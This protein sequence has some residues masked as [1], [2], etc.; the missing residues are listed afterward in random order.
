MN[1]IWIVADTFR[2]DH[3]GAYGNAAIRTP[4]LDA[5]ASRSVRFDR[6]YAAGFPT[7]PARADFFLG[8]WTMSFM[9]WG[10]LPAGATTLAQIL[11][12]AGFHTA[13]VVD[14]PFFIRHDM[15]Y[16]RGFQNFVFISGQEGSNTRLKADYHHESRDLHYAR[17]FESDLNA[18]RTISQA[19]KW[20]ELHYR[21]DFFLYID[22]WD[23]HE[24]WDAPAYYTEPYWAGFDGEEIQPPYGFWQNYADFS[25]ERVQKA[26]A[27][28]CGEIGMVDTWIG[29]LL[30][31]IENMGLAENTVIIFTSDHGFYF[32][33]HDGWFGKL[34]LGL[35]PDGTRY[36]IGDPGASWDFSPLYEELVAAPLLIYAPGIAPAACRGLTSAVD[37]MPTVLEALGQTPPGWVEGQSLWPM[38]NDPARAGREFVVSGIPFANPGYAVR[39]VDDTNRTLITGPETT[40]TADEWSLIYSL[41]PGLSQLFHLP[42]D[43]GQ[44]R[45]RIGERPE[46]ARELHALL[47]RFMAETN[48]APALAEPRSVLRL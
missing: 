12:G 44:T 17:R 2:K 28:Y 7:M 6:H 27:S 5:L 3:L 9:H 41:E 31:R 33:E 22:T 25:A 15:N 1:V 35:K 11:S 48:L 20:L 46:M 39:S 45:N 16:D 23:P 8:R 4:A 37:L 36:R 19:M 43:P 24:P 42:T 26:H 14:T 34:S 29:Y 40:V 10:P 21:E 18:P 47:T 38:V 13:A 30:Q 32:G